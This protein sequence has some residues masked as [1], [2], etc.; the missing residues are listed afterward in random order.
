MHQFYKIIWIL[1][2]FLSACSSDH[3]TTEDVCEC[4]DL[5]LD[6][7]YNH[8]FLTDR[9]IGYTGKCEQKEKNGTLVFEKNFIEGKMEGEMIIYYPSGKIKS[10]KNYK[11]NKQHG[12]QYDLSE[13]GDTLIKASFD[14]G[15][16]D[17]VYY[18]K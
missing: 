10:I 18:S 9:T 7:A 13:S 8:F 2:I 1:V 16:Q 3:G 4:A 6:V 14:R 11:R 15:E 5:Q 17:S 12:M